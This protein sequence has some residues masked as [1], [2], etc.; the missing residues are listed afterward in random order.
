MHAGDGS[1]EG[2]VRRAGRWGREA[3]LAR[4]RRPADGGM[5][6]TGC[7]GGSFSATS[8]FPAGARGCPPAPEEARAG[9]G[10]E[11]A[12][13][14]CGL[15]SRPRA[16]W[17]R[18][19]RPRTPGTPRRRRHPGRGGRPWVRRAP[20]EGPGRRRVRPPR[21]A[22][23]GRL[24]CPRRGNRPP[25]T[26]ATPPRAPPAR[27]SRTPLR[28]A[29][30]PPGRPSGRVTGPDGSREGRRRVGAVSPRVPSRRR[31]RRPP[32]A[33]RGGPWCSP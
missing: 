2:A 15:R 33:I 12:A 19:G 20:G 6:A 16:P 14:A 5:S 29:P 30:P 17:P 10:H 21:R 23:G 9:D 4:T 7:A 24:Q 32:G 1:R 11:P 31:R 22:P 13:L 18:A 25:A 28:A 8:R 3:V 26:S 27:P